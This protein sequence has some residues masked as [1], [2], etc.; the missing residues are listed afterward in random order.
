MANR[1]PS[2][3]PSP[4]LRHFENVCLHVA[5]KGSMNRQAYAWFHDAD[6]MDSRPHALP[7]PPLLSRHVELIPSADALRR[8][9]TWW[10]PQDVNRT[11]GVTKYRTSASDLSNG[12][13]PRS[14]TWLRNT[15]WFV[16]VSHG[17]T[18]NLWT[19]ICH[20]SNSMFPLFEAAYHGAVCRKPLQNVLLWQVPGAVWKNMAKGYH[21]GTI[22]AVL[23][24]YRRHTQLDSVVPPPELPVKYWFEEDI[25]AGMTFCF[26][27]LVVVKEPNL[28]HRKLTLQ[29][30]SSMSTAGVARGFGAREVRYAFRRAV[31]SHLR[32]PPPEPRVPTITHL[33][34]PFGVKDAK[35]H[36]RAWQLRC[37]IKPST[38]RRLQTDV[39][40][41][42]G[43]RMVRAVFEKTT[44]AYQAKVISET[45][46]FWSAHGAGMVHLPLLPRDAV[47]VEMF[48][49]GHFSYLYANLALNLGVRYFVMQR[50]E[51]Y[52]YKPQSLYGD[53]RKNMSKTYAFTHEEAEPVL[54]QAVRYH[55]WQDPGIE[56]N[57]REPRCETARKILNSTG[58]LPLGMSPRRWR[59]ECL[60]I[61]NATVVLRN[62]RR[63]RLGAGRRE[64][65]AWGDGTPGQ[66]TRWAGLG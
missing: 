62:P 59:V 66:Y 42:S 48:N 6:G 63:M 12:H 50:T 52:C 49:C 20:W 32:L 24:E 13:R 51:P 31:L 41:E 55:M 22:E 8:V 21:R 10:K 39:F 18:P 4:L 53:T 34:R 46:I 19:N 43:Y 5:Y 58:T 30:R 7:D 47:A 57:G 14:V 3:E 9:R 35:L 2:R 61:G 65:P 29:T 54:M 27:E 1:S 40:K 44:Y 36:G 37:H 23:E 25:A 17:G 33:S 56:V 16:D 64:D 60:G 38:F 15:S 11:V 26:D 45:D 28:Q